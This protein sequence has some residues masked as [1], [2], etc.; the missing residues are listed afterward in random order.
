MAKILGG[1][2]KKEHIFLRNYVKDFNARRAAEASGFD[3]EAGYTLLEKESIKTALEFIVSESFENMTIDA[4]W[5]LWELV[6]NHK[7][8][9][10]HGNI[11]AS[12]TALNTIAKHVS[13][14]ALAK[15]QVQLDVIGDDE[16]VKRMKL[17][18]L[19]AAGLL[20]DDNVEEDISFL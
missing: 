14:D 1:L 8:A 17:G 10:Q 3:P 2:T 5:L 15:Q 9:R 12:N 16:I 6:D 20:Q 11:S 18:R 19:R 13:V 7:I 4:E